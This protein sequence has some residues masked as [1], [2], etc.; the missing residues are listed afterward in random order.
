MSFYSYR[1]NGDDLGPGRIA[2]DPA[3]GLCERVCIQVNRVYDSCMQQE[4]LDNLR[5]KLLEIDSCCGDLYEPFELVSVRSVSSRGVI[6][7]LCIDRLEERPNCARVR[8]CVE[9]PVEVAFID[10]MGTE[11]KGDS[12]IS[13]PKDVILFVP[14]ESV[15]PFTADAIAS[16]V[17]VSGTY[18]GNKTFSTTCCVTVI[19]K[20][21]AEVE[22]LIP[23]YGF[24]R[25]PPCEEFASEVCDEFFSLPLFPPAG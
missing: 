2:N 24:C 1:N 23:S 14:C 6:R 16:A 19:L 3:R 22:L 5:I 10:S 25:I 18:I 4:Q 12:I 8:C 20:I 13:I 15:I 9:I 17:S 21:V 7:D 11:C